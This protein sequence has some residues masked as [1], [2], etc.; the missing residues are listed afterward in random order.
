MSCSA[1][2]RNTTTRRARP[3]S[4]R[5][6]SKWPTLPW[7]DLNEVENAQL[8]RRAPRLHD[9]VIVLITIWEIMIYYRSMS[10]APRRSVD[11]EH[12][13]LAELLLRAA[14]E[15]KFREELDRRAISLTPA[16]GNI[17]RYVDSNPG[18]SPSAVAEATGLLRTNLSSAVR[19][20]SRIGFIER[21]ADPDDG[22][23][24]RLYACAAAHENLAQIRESWASMMVDVVPAD[25]DL[26]T[27][28]RVLGRVV[29]G[30]VE[31]RR[32]AGLTDPEGGGPPSR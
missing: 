23:S 22:R 15:I 9:I 17:M 19:E 13:D 30:L 26:S 11:R 5:P 8:L 20:L 16:Q 18:C 2:Q 21:R 1:R 10:S 32:A 25:T 7:G 3:P 28:L 24:A 14:R 6:R 27:I 4:R 29:D 31:V 12:A